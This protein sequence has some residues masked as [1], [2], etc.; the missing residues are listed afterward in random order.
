VFPPKPVGLKGRASELGTLARIVESTRPA[1]IALVGSGGSGKSMLAAALG[2]RLSPR[3]GGRIHWFRIGAWDFHTLTEMLALRFAT[4][5]DDDHRVSALRT[6]LSTQETLIVLDNHEDDAA[7]AQLLQAFGDTRASFVITARRCLL[8]GVSIY[9]VS[10]PFATVGR[11]AF[12]RVVALTRALRYNPL[13]LDIA[14]SIVASRAA[15]VRELGASLRDGGLGSISVI[16]HEDDLPEV[17][18]L[19]EWAWQRL[20][21][22]SRRVLA[23]LAH[24]EGDHMDLSSI[25][26]LARLGARAPRA[27]LPLMAWHLVQ[28][29]V[30]GRYTV[31]AVVRHAVRRWTA[32]DPERLFRHYVRLL[33]RR[34]E[35]F[36][37]EQTHLFAAMDHAHRTSDLAGLLRIERLLQRIGGRG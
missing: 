33:E 23:V 28:E 21:G 20:P 31:H 7:T 22:T 24:T 25:A 34:P 5:R 13:A 17:R 35:R 19:V 30:E 15:T 32:P 2:H 27:L 12:P 29:P 10:A 37:L 18:L 8:A 14:D 36:G 4:A 3:F 1:R 16:E 9:P 11:S 6:W 26:V